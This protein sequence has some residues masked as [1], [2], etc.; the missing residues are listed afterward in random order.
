MFNNDD[1][2][3]WLKDQTQMELDGNVANIFS[4]ELML[5]SIR[6]LEF[7]NRSNYLTIK[8]YELKQFGGKKRKKHLLKNT[9]NLKN[10]EKLNK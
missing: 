4:A 2:T 5:K 6:N 10:T 9:E 7:D 1:N 3:N 8:V